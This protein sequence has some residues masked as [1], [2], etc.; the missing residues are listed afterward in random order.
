M[1]ADMQCI[2]HAAERSNKWNPYKKG[3]HVADTQLCIRINGCLMQVK[4]NAE[5]ATC[6]ISPVLGDHLSD[7]LVY[8]S[9]SDVLTY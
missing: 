7:M 4:I 9:V 8:V 1:P 3:S 5:R 2:M 6:N